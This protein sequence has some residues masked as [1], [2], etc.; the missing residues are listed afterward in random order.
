MNFLERLFGIDL[1]TFLLSLPIILIALVVHEV[2]HGYIAMKLGDPTAR[3][4]GRLTLNPLKHL[5]PIGTICM[6]FFHFGWAK[7]VPINTRYFKKPKRDM[8]LTALA[9]PVSNFI[10]GFFGILVYRILY[11]IFTNVAGPTTPDLAI[12]VMN[13]TLNFFYMFGFLNVSL[14]V[15][16][17]I[18]I[19]P[20]DG[21]RILLV[22]LPTKAYFAVMKYERYIMIG[23]FVLLF[24][25]RR[26]GFIFSPI[27]TLVGW[28]IDGMDWLIRLIPGL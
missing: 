9:G 12:N 21:S 2:S 3:N 10:L 8:A 13:T 7:P 25:G 27:S 28:I 23:F 5:D 26:V 6:V 19:P 15:F 18:P 4:L 17:L 1:K 14:G 20:L 24:V 22:F 16:N 11:A